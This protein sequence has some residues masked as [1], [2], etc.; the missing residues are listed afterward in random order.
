MTL[1]DLNTLL[2]VGHCD[3]LLLS[4]PVFKVSEGHK[5]QMLHLGERI[6]RITDV[7]FGNLLTSAKK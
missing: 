4:S 5:S 3:T 1:T 2:L 6:C 7:E